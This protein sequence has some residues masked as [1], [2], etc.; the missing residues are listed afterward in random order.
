M[1]AA[2][3]LTAALCIVITLISLAVVGF[4]T[5]AAW[6]P[7]TYWSKLSAIALVGFGGAALL[8]WPGFRRSTAA[9]A[10]RAGMIFPLLVGVWLS[11]RSPSGSPQVIACVLTAI[12]SCVF[13][14]VMLRN[15]GFTLAP[16]IALLG[17][18]LLA[19]ELPPYANWGDRLTF[20]YLFP[21]QPP[22]IGPGGRLRP[23]VSRR[24]AIPGSPWESV[25]LQ[26]N[27]LG[28][29]NREE[30]EP[31]PTPDRYRILSLGDSMSIGYGT[32]QDRFFGAVLQGQ[33]ETRGRP[34]EVL[35]AEVSD[36]AYG[37][38][39]LQQYGVGFEPDLV[40]YGLCGNDPL[41]TFLSTAAGSLF[42]LEPDGEFRP[43]PGA[44]DDQQRR[45]WSEWQKVTYA[46]PGATPLVS[47][48]LLTSFRTLRV[49]E[50]LRRLIVGFDAGRLTQGELT[51][52]A[53]GRNAGWLGRMKLFDGYNNLGNLVRERLEPAEQ[54]YRH[55]FPVLEAMA[56]TAQK[57]GAE[58]LLVLFPTRLQVQQQDW[59]AVIE[60]WNLDESEFDLDQHH[61]RITDFCR[62]AGLRCVDLAPVFRVA[63]RSANLYQPYDEHIGD[64][65]H[66]VAA[67]ETAVYI[68]GQLRPR[69]EIGVS[70]APD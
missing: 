43:N 61:R 37:L 63:A 15:V 46:T 55:L 68:L 4:Q 20:Q 21:H 31:R 47:P 42:A 38:H 12:W 23:T 48:D 8:A 33:L 49:V 17:V 44:D 10:V 32:E 5:Y 45:T 67:E 41:Q 30:V 27:N 36:P 50:R 13:A 60:R 56:T 57:R 29:R 7:R 65:G 3:L 18:A 6:A 14:S 2:D 62:E 11:I 34:A 16:T 39:Y 19:P 35:N 59:R 24:M 28:F 70:A 26:T 25:L 66:A 54:M 53:G 58:F 40:I 52:N 9:T 51:A 22:Y 1:R 69:R 64:A